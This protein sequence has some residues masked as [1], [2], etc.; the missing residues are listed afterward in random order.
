M[1]AALPLQ[2]ILECILATCGPQVLVLN[3]C[4]ECPGWH[5]ASD[6]GGEIP[7]TNIDQRC[8]V[9]THCGP[10]E[11]LNQNVT[12]QPL[13]RTEWPCP[14]LGALRA[15]DHASS[16]DKST[17]CLAPR[18]V[19]GCPVFRRNSSAKAFKGRMVGASLNVQ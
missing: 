3:P 7:F 12:M 10:R 19:V 18:V 11:L 4:P 15:K 14:G 5:T 9:D 13:A 16:Q 1:I 2:V 8:S 17:C 6:L